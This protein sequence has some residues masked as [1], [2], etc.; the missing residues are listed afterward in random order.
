MKGEEEKERGDRPGRASGVF[1]R[2]REKA[3]K[4]KNLS[5]SLHEAYVWHHESH[6]CYNNMNSHEAAVVLSA[7]CFFKALA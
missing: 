7:H 1:Q 4:K 5:I 2:E 6:H 3:R